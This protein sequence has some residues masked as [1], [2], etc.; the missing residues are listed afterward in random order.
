MKWKRILREADRL[1]HTRP[2]ANGRRVKVRAET[3]RGDSH[4]LIGRYA[5]DDDT[6]NGVEISRGTVVS[7]DTVRSEAEGLT[8][9][10]PTAQ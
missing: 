8:E 9:G 2:K 3:R 1:R 7:L 4:I 10:R 6:C 5:P